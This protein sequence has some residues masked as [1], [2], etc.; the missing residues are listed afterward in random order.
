MPDDYKQ[1]NNFEHDEDDDDN[2]DDKG[3]ENDK[4]IKQQKIIFFGFLFF[5][6][7][8]LFLAFYQLRYNL[9]APFFIDLSGE[10]DKELAQKQDDIFI[11]QKKDT[12]KDG[13]S[14][15]DELYVYHTSPYLEDSDSDG[16]NDK[17][18]IDSNNDPNCPK[19]KDCNIYMSD[20]IA[21]SSPA[22]Q[23][24]YDDLINA[25][26]VSEQVDA[27]AL[28]Q[29]LLEQGIP[30]DVL[31]LLSDE[32]LLNEYANAANGA[33]PAAGTENASTDK[34]QLMDLSADEIRDVLKSKG[35]DEKILNGIDDATLKKD[36]VDTLNGL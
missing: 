35:I 4:N 12:D 22:L 6:V 34:E 30:S 26:Q 21:S 3:E 18:E 5:G 13:L 14:D 11:L 24:I 31:D 16:F 9:R 7:I 27:R 25:G 28:R 10:G 15:Y 2:N 23:D 17:G 1:Y 33:S 29:Y 36:F 8:A 20:N 19:G 32:E